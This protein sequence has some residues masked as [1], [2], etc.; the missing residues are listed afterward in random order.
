MNLF[1]EVFRSCWRILVIM[2]INE[3]NRE[4]RDEIVVKFKAGLAYKTLNVSAS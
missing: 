4:V 2:K 3:H 1:Y